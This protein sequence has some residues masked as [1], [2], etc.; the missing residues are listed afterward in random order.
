MMVSPHMEAIV[1]WFKTQVMLT[2][3]LED[4]DIQPCR[5]STFRRV[6]SLQIVGLA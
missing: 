2:P 5:V 4:L 3:Q 1:A 6:Y